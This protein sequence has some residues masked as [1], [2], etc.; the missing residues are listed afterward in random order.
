MAKKD[1]Y[2]V[3][4]VSKSASADE[5]KKAYRKLAMKF[6]PDK[7]PGNKSAEESFKEASEAYEVL[8]DEKKRLNYDQ[9]GFAGAGAF[10][11]RQ[12]GFER[13]PGGFSG[14]DSEQF[15]D[16]F[17]DI[18]GDVFGGRGNYR[19]NRKAKGADLRYTLNLTLEE[20]ILG[21]EKI[22]SFIRQRSGK[23]ETAKLSVKVPPRVKEGQRLKL[24]SEGDSPSG[25]SIP[26]D[27]YVIINVQSHPI[28]ERKDDDLLV[29]APVSY[30]TAILG[31]EV[32]VPTLT[33]SIVLKV[34][35]GTHSGQTL[36]VKGKG[37]LKANGFGSG[38]ILVSIVVDTPN[39]LSQ[40]EK[41]LFNELLSISNET[42]LV[43]N[44]KEKVKLIQRTKK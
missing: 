26:G 12:G 38:D 16:I 4:G 28:F 37:I 39:Q 18:F 41:E 22:I 20:A 2:S 42:P 17:G 1:Y 34:P 15:Q 35:A 33:G 21:C 6:H 13:G 29:T 27:L 25:V 40:R 10:S 7:N 9:F 8:S 43:R 30:L 11:G 5:I 3:L 24:N 31:G 36:R 23:D 14:S 19:Q 44:Y 32:E